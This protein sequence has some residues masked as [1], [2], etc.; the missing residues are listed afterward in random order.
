ML[1]R[2][3]READAKAEAYRDREEATLE[4]RKVEMESQEERISQRELTLENRL[5]RQQVA[6]LD[7]GDRRRA[8]RLRGRHRRRL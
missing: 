8:G 7:Y 6:R 1:A 5:L 4:H 3:E 2:A